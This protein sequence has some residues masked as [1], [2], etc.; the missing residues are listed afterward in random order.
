MKL[1]RKEEVAWAAG[2][3]EGEG[4]IYLRRFAKG[5]K[6]NVWVYGGLS[7]EM[8][9]KDVIYKVQRI[10][11]AG[12]VIEYIPTT[13][14]G[15]QL[16]YRWRVQNRAEFKKVVKLIRPYLGKRRLKKLREVEKS[17][18]AP[19]QHHNAVKVNSYRGVAS[20]R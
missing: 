10:F 3:F 15:R 9:D 6:Q 12:T 7:M 17:L 14:L 11:D 4:S 18:T 19:S 20:V 16:T 1:T 8:V 13:G 2:V 5:K